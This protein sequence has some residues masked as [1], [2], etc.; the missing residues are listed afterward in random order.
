MNLL[1]WII[2]GLVIIG[3]I[4]AAVFLYRHKG[5]GCSGN[6]MECYKEQECNKEQNCNRK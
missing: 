2:L 6:C 1:S 5:A 4:G 3:V